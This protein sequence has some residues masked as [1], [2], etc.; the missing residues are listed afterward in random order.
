VYSSTDAEAGWDASNGYV[1]NQDAWSGSAGPQT[2]YACNYNS[3]SVSS[4]Q[5]FDN[6]WGVETYPDTEW[7]FVS[8][9]YACTMP[10]CGPLISDI[11]SVPSSFNF[12]APATGTGVI[13]DNAYD[14]WVNGLNE[15]SSMEVMVWN[16]YSG[17]PNPCSGLCPNANTTGDPPE[18][19]I[20]GVE[21][22]VDHVAQPVLSGNNAG[23]GLTIFV[24]AD[25]TSA[26]T[27]NLLPVYQYMQAQGWIDSSAE[28]STVEYGV[29]I[30]LTNGYQ[31]YSL[32]N[33]S[34]GISCDSGDSCG[35]DPPG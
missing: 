10:D 25:Q 21:Y 11:T 20:D 8:A 24:L 28:L 5:S 6:P 14:T 15:N 34:L 35:V 3:W 1:V 32:N 16:Q 27:V 31:T 13:Y 29:E 2:L 22:Y 17:Q 23:A 19:D 30:G 7:D 9:P 26:G 33:Y 4:D 18:A 12:T